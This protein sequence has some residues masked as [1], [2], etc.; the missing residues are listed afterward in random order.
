MKKLLKRISQ[1]QSGNLAA[2]IAAVYSMM[3]M[4][5]C[6]AN[7]VEVNNPLDDS[8]IYTLGLRGDL[9]GN[10]N[11]DADEIT[12]GMVPSKSV[13]VTF[14]N[15]PYTVEPETYDPFTWITASWQTG[16]EA[17]MKWPHSGDAI[18]CPQ[19]V[20]I[21]DDGDLCYWPMRFV[22]VIS[23]RP[24]ATQTIFLRFRWDG[25]V[26]QELEV[27]SG[28]TKGRMAK[29]IG[30]VAQTIIAFGWSY[31][32]NTGWSLALN[33]DTS[34]NTGQMSIY[35]GNKSTNLGAVTVT[36]G[37]WQDM[38]FTIKPSGDSSVTVTQYAANPSSATPTE[39]KNTGTL[40]NSLTFASGGAVSLQYGGQSAGSGWAKIQTSPNG[41][42][43]SWR[44]T[45]R[46]VKIWNRELKD[47]E[48]RQVVA[49]YYGAKWRIGAVNGSAAEFGVDGGADAPAVSYDPDTMPWLKMRG[50]LTAANP[51]LTVCGAWTPQDRAVALPRTLSITPIFDGTGDAPCPIEVRVNGALAASGNLKEEAGRN[52]FIPASFWQPDGSG[53]VSVS[54][55]RTGSL[56][57]T[58]LVDALELGGSWQVGYRDN[59]QSD[60][61]K[62]NLSH[63]YYFAG[64]P[65]ASNMNRTARHTQI[66]DLRV[67]IP[68]WLAARHSFK[69]ESRITGCAA[70]TGYDYAAQTVGL[71]VNGHPLWS[72]NSVTATR[73]PSLVFDVPNE[74]LMPG[75][76]V[77][78]WTNMTENAGIRNNAWVC[79]DYQCLR[80]GRMRRGTYIS[81]R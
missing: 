64:D 42:T 36:P 38:F 65:V 51:S 28:E 72:T 69:Y 4:A 15:G 59:S 67:H 20:K 71:L 2:R 10:G 32:S 3:T 30:T 17:A 24:G 79:F 81:I 40:A 57:G 19:P 7:A 39:G 22:H 25:L 47:L 54:V 46:E 8:L 78:R 60:M 62:N 34:K 48:R 53:N 55:T 35:C 70:N 5:I 80:V 1:S 6:V 63:D 33:V 13:S 58:V 37:A 31:A 49:G 9:N 52:L 77:F 76:N 45:I 26:A 11:L 73:N 14:S 56:T 23:A 75:I 68:E 21:D 66:V 41:V 16:G 18:Y 44:G 74:M 61:S 50:A 27:P 43:K 29:Y 12:N